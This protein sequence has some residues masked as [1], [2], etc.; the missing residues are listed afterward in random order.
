MLYLEAFLIALSTFFLDDRTQFCSSIQQ[1]CAQHQGVNKGF[2]PNHG[3]PSPICH[4]FFWSEHVTSF[5]SMRVNEK[6]TGISW[7][8][9]FSLIK[10][11][12]V[13][14]DKYPHLSLAPAFLLWTC[15]CDE[16]LLQPPCNHKCMAASNHGWQSKKVARAWTC[17]D[18]AK[19]LNYPVTDL[20][21]LGPPS[22]RDFIKR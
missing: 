3:N 2:S 16:V 13:Q 7:E 9:Y 4:K 18:I 10:K 21:N 22:S 17:S 1:P 19:P 6:S 8:R 11:R 5:W 12:Q 20:L 14:G 15:L